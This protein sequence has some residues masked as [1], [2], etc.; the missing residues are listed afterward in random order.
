MVSG[1][2]EINTAGTHRVDQPMFLT[3][4]ARPGPR[5]DVPQRFR[6]TDSLERI[7]H[8]RFNQVENPEGYAPVCFDPEPKVLTKLRVEN[9]K[10]LRLLWQG[11]S[12]VAAYRLCG[13]SAAY[14]AHAVGRRATFLRFSGSEAGGPFP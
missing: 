8:D 11:R 9:R 3:D 4:P 13:A 6:F 5:E 2:K 12:L 1:L 14:P 10:A 7:P